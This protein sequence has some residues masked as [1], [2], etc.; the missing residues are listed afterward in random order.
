MVHPAAGVVKTGAGQSSGC[1]A[2]TDARAARGRCMSRGAAVRQKPARYHSSVRMEG[3]SAP[4]R[5][6]AQLA[7]SLF[8]SP[9]PDLRLALDAAQGIR[10]RPTNDYAQRST[11]EELWQAP[12]RSSRRR[13]DLARPQALYSPAGRR[14]CIPRRAA[15]A[16]RR[17]AWPTR[18]RC[19]AT[20]NTP[21]GD[22]ST[23]TRALA[24]PQTHAGPI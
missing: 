16:A 8:V 18:R 23:T 11:A 20:A 21:P 19:D 14:S 22:E 2:R 13:G 17:E 5:P 1:S 3:C 24:S 10:R 12:A 9:S 4:Q 6:V 15:Y 7:T